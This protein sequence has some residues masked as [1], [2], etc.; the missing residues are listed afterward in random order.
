ME[1]IS[2]NHTTSRRAF[3]Q[4]LLFWGCFSGSGG[5]GPMVYV[6]RTMN[7][8]TYIN[9]LQN[10]F[11]PYKQARFHTNRCIF[12]HDNA[13]S[14][15]S[16][17]TVHFLQ[18]NNIRTIEWPPYSPDLNPIENMWSVIKKK[19]HQKPLPTREDVCT[20][21][22]EAWNDPSI[23]ELCM[24]LADSMVDRITAC[25]ASKGGYTQY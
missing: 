17:P 15:K 22:E 23:H 13:P 16:G 14:H 6:P 2:D 25:I 8:V 3:R 11:V 5:R 18:V 7:T 19:I 4:R 10:H 24:K 20:S 1:K 9:T 21:V 12:Q